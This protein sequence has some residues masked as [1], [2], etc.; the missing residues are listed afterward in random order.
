MVTSLAAALG[1]AACSGGGGSAGPTTTHAGSRV[2]TTTAA[3]QA[4]LAAEVNS[5]TTTGNEEIQADQTTTDPYAEFTAESADFST[6]ASDLQDLSFPGADSIDAQALESTLQKE[7]ADAAQIASDMVHDTPDTTDVAQLQKDEQMAAADD[8]ALRREVGL[9]PATTT[10]TTPIP[11]TT[12]TSSTSTTQP[13]AR[14]TASTTSTTVAVSALLD[15]KGQGVTTTE[16]FSVPGS[17]KEWSW[18]WTY[19]CAALGVSGNFIVDVLPA[20]EASSTGATAT[21][22]TSTKNTSSTRAS[23]GNNGTT[24]DVGPN[25]LGDAGQGAEHYFDTG[26]FALKITSECTWSVVVTAA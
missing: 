20:G 9:S 14:A 6:T 21:T 13:A 8:H 12:S 2:T 17:A 19:D 22:G 18:A 16:A 25:E 10:S 7:S 23:S 15:Q 1:L 3:S 5:A 24:T 11:S 26:R 4:S